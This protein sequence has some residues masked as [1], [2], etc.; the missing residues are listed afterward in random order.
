[1]LFLSNQVYK[2]WI[3]DKL[4]IPFNLSLTLFLYTVVIMWCNLFAIIMNGIGKVKLQTYFSVFSII[5]NIPL[6]IL[7]TKYFN[8]GVLGIPLATCVSMVINGGLISLQY[9]LV[10][11]SK[12][13][14]V[15]NK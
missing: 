12:A 10:I 3:G 8:W 5:I 4:L 13:L 6:S 2:I 11:N 9:Y 1:M 15:F 14:G 7:F